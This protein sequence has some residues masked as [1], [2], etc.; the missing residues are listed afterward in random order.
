M[1]LRSLTQIEGVSENRMLRRVFGTKREYVAGGWRTL[2]NEE[3][4]NL[5]ASINIIRVIKSRMRWVGHVARMGE[6]RNVYSIFVGKLE[7]KRPLGRPRRGCENNI[8]MDLR[9][10]AWE[11]VDWIHLARDW[12]SGGLL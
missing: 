8:R 9:E 5:Y 10:I 2:H 12:T 11:G 7:G 1:R 4:H 3:L 6:T